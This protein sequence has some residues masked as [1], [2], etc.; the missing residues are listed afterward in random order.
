MQNLNLSDLDENDIDYDEIIEYDEIQTNF[1]YVDNDFL[2]E[3]I[4]NHNK[5]QK[6]YIRI[7]EIKDLWFMHKLDNIN[8]VE[9]TFKYN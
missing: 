1:I 8:E 7:T 6:V 2:E 9:V 4:K 5:I 3:S